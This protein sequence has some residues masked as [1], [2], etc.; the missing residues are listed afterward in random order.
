MGCSRIITVSHGD[1]FSVLTSN[2]PTFFL[3]EGVAGDTRNIVIGAAG[4]FSFLRCY[5]ESN[6]RI[7]VQN[8]AIRVN[9]TDSDLLFSIPAG[10]TGEFSNQT[11]SAAITATDTYTLHKYNGD[12]GI[13]GF[14]AFT[15]IQV[16]FTVPGSSYHQVIGCSTQVPTYSSGFNPDPDTYYDNFAGLIV[17]YVNVGLNTT[18]EEQA[19][20]PILSDGVL[21]NMQV[22][23]RDVPTRLLDDVVY[24]IRINGAY[25]NQTVTVPA[26][27]LGAFVDTVNTDEVEIDD[28]LAYE[29]EYPGVSGGS[30][31]PSFVAVALTSETNF[32]L[33]ASTNLEDKLVGEIFDPFY[34]SV[35]GDFSFDY[36][37]PEEIISF[38]SF[39]V[40]LRELTLSILYS[41]T[42]D[43]CR[44]DLMKTGVA[45]TL[46]VVIP[47]G[48][49]G[50]FNVISEE[51]ISA[52]DQL[53]YRISSDAG[54]GYLAVGW[55]ILGGQ[56]R[57]PTSVPSLG[58]PGI[59]GGAD[60]SDDIRISL[61]L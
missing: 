30:V 31:S 55:A 50:S 46:G 21:S 18:T 12:G 41:E 61:N 17:P 25:G 7:G 54:D 24:N 35:I 20:M 19:E 26:G 59:F 37:T 28:V 58:S 36:T 53:A 45:T 16:T 9:D 51:N 38:I 56:K 3:A 57:V 34:A 49:T 52:G 27:A 23:M 10:A 43:D 39:S 42:F 32:S 4:T 48:A 15:S 13:T 5:V 22:G 14:L 40:V 1:A 29:T 47:G 44:I 60:L 8:F 6:T 11:D 2:G 33:C